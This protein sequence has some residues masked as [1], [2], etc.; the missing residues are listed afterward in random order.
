V[1]SLAVAAVAAIY[2]LA[3]PFIFPN[4]R[5]DFD[6][7]WEAARAWRM[8]ADPYATILATHQSRGLSFG[9]VFPFS[10]VVCAVPLSYLP[11]AVARA[12]VAGSGACLLAWLVLGRGW[13]LFPV[14]LSGAMRASV[15]L[16][17]V[18]PFVAASVLLPSLGWVAAIKPNVGLAALVAQRE[19]RAVLS[20]AVAASVLV[21]VS[22][23][24]WPSWP[25]AW[26]D[27]V[28]TGETYDPLVVRAGGAVLLL[29]AIRWRR[30]EA[31]WLLATTLLPGTPAAYDA[32]PLLVLLPQ[33]FRQA[34]MFALLSAAS[35]LGAYLI[36]HTEKIADVARVRAIAIIWALY[37]PALVVILARPNEQRHPTTTA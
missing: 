22:L 33:T 6:Q 11:L 15:S 13:W 9:L 7:L 4:Y 19:R 21:V 5:S 20:F 2:V 8:G 10:A 14:L 16:V 28:A 27:G 30:P 18:A 32:L 29:A 17:Q 35:D 25:W 23:M 12:I 26:R 36:P 31:R 34:L 1:W 37:V 24:L 3:S